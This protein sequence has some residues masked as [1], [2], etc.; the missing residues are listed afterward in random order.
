MML[1]FF[2]HLG[3]GRGRRLIMGA[4]VFALTYIIAMTIYGYMAK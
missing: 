1:P 2:D 3:R 4:G